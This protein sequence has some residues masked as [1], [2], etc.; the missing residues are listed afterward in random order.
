MA[1][2]GVHQKESRHGT[3]RQVV[4]LGSDSKKHWWRS[5][6]RKGRE[7]AS[8]GGVNE[9]DN[10]MCTG[11]VSPL[12]SSGEWG[13]ERTH[14]R[15]GPAKGWRSWNVHLPIPIH[16]WSE[17]HRK[18]GITRCRLSRAGASP[19]GQN[20]RDLRKQATSTRR[21]GEGQEATGGHWRRVRPS[22]ILSSSSSPPLSKESHFQRFHFSAICLYISKLHT[23]TTIH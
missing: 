5:Q 3:G 19:Q 8:L 12:G 17:G 15:T 22:S 21:D 18:W 7:G 20:C 4:S 16:C 14:L 9:Q 2:V 6:E 10:T 1:S 23:Y 13:M 11:G